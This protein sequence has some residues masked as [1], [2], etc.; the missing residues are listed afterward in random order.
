M[1]TRLLLPALFTLLLLAA[2]AN[3]TSHPHHVSPGM[4]KVESPETLVSRFLDVVD[5]D[6]LMILDQRL[7]SV[8]LNPVNVQYIYHLDGSPPAYKIHA[9]LKLPVPLPKFDDCYIAAVTVL[10]KPTGE[11]V[12]VQAHIETK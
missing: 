6:G 3:A 12:E 11:V 2:D 9:S 4:M 7:A 1:I 10:V 8:V 5:R